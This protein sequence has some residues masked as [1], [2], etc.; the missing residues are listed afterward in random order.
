M[1]IFSPNTFFSYW[2]FSLN[3]SGFVHCLSNWR[4]LFIWIFASMQQLRTW[5][6]NMHRGEKEGRWSPFTFLRFR[7]SAPIIQVCTSSSSSYSSSLFKST[8]LQQQ[9]RRRRKATVARAQ[10]LVS[11]RKPQLAGAARGNCTL[12][13]MLLQDDQPNEANASSAPRWVAAQC[14]SNHFVSSLVSFCALARCVHRG[15]AR[16]KPDVTF[17]WRWFL[18]LSSRAVNHPLRTSRLLS[19]LFWTTLRTASETQQ[20]HHWRK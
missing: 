14:N 7:H 20:Q 4:F 12:R 19:A 11:E 13:H 18:A 16:N 8:C 15:G 3:L 10:K 6:R 9:R 1:Y 17:N 2:A 5:G